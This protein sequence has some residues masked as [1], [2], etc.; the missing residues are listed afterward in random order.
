MYVSNSQAL[1]KDQIRE[2]APSVFAS[3]PS[4]ITGSN[5]GFVSS[6]EALKVFEDMGWKVY[7]A[8]ESRINALS[9]EHY[10][11]KEIARQEARR[12]FQTHILKLRHD[13]IEGFKPTKVG[14]LW[15]EIVFRN[16][17]DG[18]S[19]F[20]LSFG[21]FRLICT[22]GMVTCEDLAA[23]IKIKHEGFRRLDVTSA[24]EALMMD[25]SKVW[26]N[27][28]DMKELELTPDQKVEFGKWA[29]DLRQ[30][31]NKIDPLSI[32]EPQREGDNASDLFTVFNVAQEYLIRGGLKIVKDNG[33]TSKT[34]GITSIEE[35][36]RVNKELWSQ[37]HQTLNLLA[38]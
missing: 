9:P 31:G 7:G 24:I 34:R 13:S 3:A 37:A 12:G 21:L 6:I 38:A 29:L 27:V 8:Q 14:D 4:E 16:A 2:V 35:N 1:S 22:N 23:P 32:V 33:K 26:C 5:Y 18:R 17:H 28:N 36:I 11:E 20:N 15:P 19:S 30:D 10:T 25:S